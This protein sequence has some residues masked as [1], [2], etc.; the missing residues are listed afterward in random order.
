MTSFTEFK[1]QIESAE[2]SKEMNDIG[3][4]MD[5]SLERGEITP[6]EF[7]ALDIQMYQKHGFTA[8]GSPTSAYHER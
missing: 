3:W 2:T 1:N 7:V 6:D 5:A 4:A 8:T